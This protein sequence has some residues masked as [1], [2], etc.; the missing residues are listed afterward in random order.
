MRT[1]GSKNGV[2]SIGTIKQRCSRENHINSD[3]EYFNSSSSKTRFTML[4]KTCNR[5]IG[6]I[7]YIDNSHKFD[8]LNSR[9]GE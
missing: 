6:V 3:K 2:L 8:D 9:R 7:D 5:F 4:C 1:E